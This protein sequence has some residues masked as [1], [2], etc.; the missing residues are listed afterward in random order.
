MESAQGV[1]SFC[2]REGG[3]GAGEGGMIDGADHFDGAGGVVSRADG[4]A[5]F[6][7]GEEPVGYGIGGMGRRIRE[8]CGGGREW[9]P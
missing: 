8:P 2:E 3:A 4:F 9:F 6:A 5:V 7:D 1:G